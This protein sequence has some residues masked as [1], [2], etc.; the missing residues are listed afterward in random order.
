ML[1]ERDRV[2]AAEFQRLAAGDVLLIDVRPQVETSI[3][4]LPGSVNLP[5]DA[6]DRSADQFLAIV[7]RR[8]ETQSPLQGNQTLINLISF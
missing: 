5:F 8:L 3:C 2:T 1:P 4:S 6:L 7:R